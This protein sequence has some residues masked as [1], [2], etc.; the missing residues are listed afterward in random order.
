[1]KKFP[2]LGM[3]ALLLI[4]GGC[5]STKNPSDSQKEVSSVEFSKKQQCAEL[6]ES[7]KVN[8]E[9]YNAENTPH[10]NKSLLEIF[11]SREKNTC[12]EGFAR[13]SYTEYLGEKKVFTSFVLKD[14]LENKELE[15]FD[16]K[17]DYDNAI[18]KL[19]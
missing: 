3:T 1:M 17:N 12:I 2:I 15:A 14:I 18:K 16:A 11:Y 19:K 13:V 8:I 4:G 5:V 7:E 6:I 9:K 10:N